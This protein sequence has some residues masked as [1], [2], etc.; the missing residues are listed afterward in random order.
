LKLL[1]STSLTRTG[2]AALLTAGALVM[3]GA[4]ALA[5]AP[6][7]DFSVGLTGTTIAADASGK[8]GGLSVLNLGTKAADKAVLT[9][10]TADLDMSKVDLD[11]GDC[12]LDGD[13]VI[14]DLVGAE[15][16]PRPGA[17]LDYD[18]PLTRQAGASG[19]AGELSV[20][21]TVEGDAVAGNDSAT[22]KVAVGGSGVDLVVVAED[23]YAIDEDGNLTDKPVAAGDVSAVVGHVLNQGDKTAKGLKVSVELPELVTFGEKL[24]GCEY[25]ADNRTATCGFDDVSLIPADLDTEDYLLSG[26]D[27]YFIVKVDETATGP[28]LKDG[29]F[30][31]AAL[32]SAS[33]DPAAV[34][35]ARKAKPVRNATVRALAVA[36]APDVDDSDNS[37]EFAVFV[38]ADADG[39]TGGDD[40][41]EGGG[42]PV[43][44]PQAA[45][46]GGGGLA[47]AVAGALLFLSARRRRVVLVTP[48][49]ERTPTA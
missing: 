5:A 18:I 13:L 45:V 24:D 48:G 32:G 25:G 31:V 6:E 4:P 9:F 16:L 11:L 40:G 47:V 2:A 41:G 36:D 44:G 3:T 28:V 7:I 46:V 22:A 38:A 12:L 19:A 1:R 35:A 14:C 21:I 39:G 17:T 29:L 34:K 30:T 49:D 43:T 23:V 26:A 27:V 20:K 37:D 10:D 33:A 15:Y 8:F 42:L